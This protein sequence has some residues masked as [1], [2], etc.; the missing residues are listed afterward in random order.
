MAEE[1]EDSITVAARVVF[2]LGH[3][4]PRK[5]SPPRPAPHCGA[6]WGIFFFSPCPV[7][8]T[9]GTPFLQFPGPRFRLPLQIP[10]SGAPFFVGHRPRPHKL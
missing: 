1:M 4:G 8:R 3:A 5:K 9:S 2:A 6:G 10:R 7:P